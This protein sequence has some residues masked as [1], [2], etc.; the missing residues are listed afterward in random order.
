MSPGRRWFQRGS[1]NGTQNDPFLTHFTHFYPFLTHFGS[2]GGSQPRS[3][4]RGARK[5]FDDPYFRSGTPF[6]PQNGPFW[7]LFDPFLTLFWPFWPQID[8]FPL[9]KLASPDFR[10]VQKWPIL[11]SPGGLG[12]PLRGLRSHFN[13]EISWNPEIHMWVGGLRHPL[14]VS[15]TTPVDHFNAEISWNY[16]MHLWVDPSEGVKRG[17][18]GVHFGVIFDPL[19]GPPDTPFSP[20]FIGSGGVKWGSKRGPKSLFFGHFYPFLTHFWPFLDHFGPPIYLILVGEIEKYPFLDPPNGGTPFWGSILAPKSDLPI[21]PPY[22]PWWSPKWGLGGSQKG[23][24]MGPKGVQ[25][26]SK[27]GKKGSILPK[28]GQNR[29]FPHFWK[30]RKGIRPWGVRNPSKFIF[31]PFLTPCKRVIFQFTRISDPPGPDSLTFFSVLRKWP[32][33]AKK[34]SKWGL[35]CHF[36]CEKVHFCHFWGFLPFWSFYVTFICLS[37]GVMTPQNHDGGSKSE[38]V[39]NRVFEVSLF[40]PKCKNDDFGDL[41]AFHM[42]IHRCHDTRFSE[43]P[44]ST[45]KVTFCPKNVKNRQKCHFW[46]FCKGFMSPTYPFWHNLV[47]PY[48]LSIGV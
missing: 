8:R 42:S 7:P 26:G 2:F 15:Q 4:C 27:S 31:T 14:R 34:W 35:F 38:K 3:Q 13:A 40:L 41:C 37:I 45:K 30:N 21:L 25:N 5:V 44:V 46:H 22:S 6:G 47:S 1:R 33:F 11:G 48:G 19:F 17:Q 39:E 32:I 24:K 43:I 28:R 20:R 23:S 12:P 18:K 16:E 9:S 36:G 29:H 10:G